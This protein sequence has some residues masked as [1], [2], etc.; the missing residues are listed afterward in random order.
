MSQKQVQFA[1]VSTIPDSKSLS[2][3]LQLVRL[4]SR[5]VSC[6]AGHSRAAEST[7]NEYLMQQTASNRMSRPI[8]GVASRCCVVNSKYIAPAV[9][10][11]KVHRVLSKEPG[12][13]FS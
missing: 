2:E 11:K 8:K 7:A 12:Q 6:G 1:D 4:K 5:V 13:F 10:V 9:D 3:K